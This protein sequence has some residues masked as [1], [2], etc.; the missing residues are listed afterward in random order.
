MT[1]VDLVELVLVLDYGVALIDGLSE[2]DGRPC[3][4]L[5]AVLLLLPASYK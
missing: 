3:A 5:V 4:S 1:V 2:F